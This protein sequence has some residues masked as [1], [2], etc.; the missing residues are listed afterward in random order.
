MKRF[1]EFGKTGALLLALGLMCCLARRSEAGVILADA[2]GNRTQVLVADDAPENVVKLADFLSAQA[3]QIT[4]QS[5]QVNRERDAAAAW[6]VKLYFGA[7]RT[8]GPYRAKLDGLNRDGFLILTPETDK[9]IVAGNSEPALYCAVFRLLELCGVRFLMPGEDGTVYPAGRKLEL[10]DTNLVTA[11]AFESRLLSW[12]GTP[13][14][15]VWYDW[16]AKLGMIERIAFHHNLNNVLPPSQYLAA[17]PEF[18]AERRGVRVRPA[19]DND[20]ASWQLCFTAPGSADAAA[21][22]I[23]AFFAA[24]PEVESFS[25]GVN[26][27]YDHCECA[28]CTRL[29]GNRLNS[30]QV[31]HASES[32]YRWC[33][34]VAE[35]VTAA[36]PDKRFGL[37]AYDGVLDPP[38]SVKLHPALIPYITVDRYMWLDP[39]RAAAG[40][41]H[42][43]AWEKQ[44]VTLGYYDYIYGEAYIVPRLYFHHWQKV[45]GDAS[46]HGVKHFYA[47]AYSSADWAEGPWLYGTLKLLWDPSADVDALLSDWCQAAVGPAAAP[48]LLRYYANWEKFWTSDALQSAWFQKPGIYVYMDFSSRG[49]LDRLD[50][51]VLTVQSALLDEI[52]AKSNSPQ[53]AGRIKAAFDSRLAQIQ[54]YLANRKNLT[55]RYAPA[56]IIRADGFSNGIDTWGHWQRDNSAGVFAADAR[57]GHHAP[58]SL[59]IRPEGSGKQP[60]CFYNNFPVVAGKYYEVGVWT[61]LD[62]FPVDGQV[63]L[64]VKYQAGDEWLD[65]T[66]AVTVPADAARQ[67]WQELKAYVT[68]PAISVVPGKPLTIRIHLRGNNAAAGAVFWDDFRLGETTVM[69]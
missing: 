64:E 36:Y 51:S 57:V 11:P 37:L 55:R 7:T 13:Q 50:E 61:R 29:N 33:N 58:G 19:S 15:A 1:F 69:P 43:Q 22:R 30:T 40:L 54:N 62:H 4:G 12:G 2:S 35:K 3:A 66:Y 28:A 26:D 31:R 27:S 60:M 34:A 10:L 38:D 9:V 18:Y 16:A 23:K 46:A 59:V 41:A 42:Q 14:K 8:A 65:E 25:L 63:M 21:E 47:E 32:Y 49:Y 68:P 24:H 20:T 44:G 5:F 67:D 17:H 48:A 53:R 45:L 52:V 6:P 39:A 56:K